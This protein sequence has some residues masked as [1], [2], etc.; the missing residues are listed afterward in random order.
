MKPSIPKG[1]RDFLPE[2][3][4]KRKYIFNTIEKVFRKYAYVA[5]ETPTMESL[6][7]LSGNYGEEGIDSFSR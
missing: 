3:V 1:T 2:Q 7:T 6:E 5:I 4:I